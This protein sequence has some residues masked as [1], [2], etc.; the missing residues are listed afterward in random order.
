MNLHFSPPDSGGLIFL[1]RIHVAL[2]FSLLS[3]I[4][5]FFLIPL[6]MLFKSNEYCGMQHAYMR[7]SMALVLPCLFSSC[8]FTT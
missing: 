6:Q 5:F 8:N 1:V 7:C 4:L 3:S 2:I